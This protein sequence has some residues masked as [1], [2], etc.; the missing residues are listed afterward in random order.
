[1]VFNFTF[2]DSANNQYD[3]NFY[4][5]MGKA[6]YVSCHNKKNIFMLSSNFLIY[7]YDGEHDRNRSF[8]TRLEDFTLN[9]SELTNFI[10]KLVKNKAFW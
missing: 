6:L 8:R 5:E 9:H 2:K 3:L 1:M 4:P 7:D 10:I